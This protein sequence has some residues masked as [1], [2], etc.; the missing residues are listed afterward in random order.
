MHGD[1][2]VKS[3]L[4]DEACC[5]DQGQNRLKQALGEYQR[6]EEADQDH[7]HHDESGDED[8]LL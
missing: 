8:K 1:I 4:S 5:L 6:H 3:S 2:D 7:D